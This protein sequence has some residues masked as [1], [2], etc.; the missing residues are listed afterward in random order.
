MEGRRTKTGLEAR[1]EGLIDQFVTDEEKFREK[2]LHNHLKGLVNE[3]REKVAKKLAGQ[4]AMS[5]QK[6]NWKPRTRPSTHNN[7]KR[8]LG[9]EIHQQRNNLN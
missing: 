3:S 6:I 1:Q 5:S 4:A 8:D 9:R 2:V 7:A